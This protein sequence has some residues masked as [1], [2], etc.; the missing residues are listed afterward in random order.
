MIFHAPLSVGFG[1]V[2]LSAVMCCVHIQDC[3]AN[4]ESEFACNLLLAVV[5][6]V[7]AVSACT[8]QMGCG[9]S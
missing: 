8:A 5:T 3:I 9:F 1:E 6:T 7:H 2:S 4:G